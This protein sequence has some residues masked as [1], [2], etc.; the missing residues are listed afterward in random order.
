[1]PEAEVLI[2]EHL[3]RRL[4]ESQFPAWA[5]LPLRPLDAIGWD[6]TIFRL[7]DDL[8]VRL[9]R[10]QLGADVV[11]HEHRWLPTFAPRLPVPIPVPIGRGVPDLG[12]PWPWSVCPWIP[13]ELAATTPSADGIAVAEEL[14]RFVTAL[15][16]PAPADAP[17]NQF[18]G[19]PLADRDGITREA[20]NRVRDRVDVDAALGAWGDALAVPG[21]PDA[22]VWLHG[23]LHPAN[24]LVADGRL[25]GVLDFGDLTGG[26]PATDLVSG[27]MLF[28]PPAREVLRQA[29]G[30]DDDTWARARGWALAIGAA[31]MA[32]SADNPIIAA[33]GL[34]AVSAVLSES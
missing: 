34:R 20:L 31:C 18:R 15:H 17:V 8:V 33:V 5:G 21:W 24:F 16:E 32:N 3:V 10:R 30:V 2:D 29:S 13:G 28:S 27:W 26:D 1:M 19:I 12:Y 23:D 11:Q 22:K 9:P 4:L 14:G 6:N 25:S 7:G